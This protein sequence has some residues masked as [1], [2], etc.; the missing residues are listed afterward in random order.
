[1]GLTGS[2]FCFEVARWRGRGGERRESD[3]EGKTLTRTLTLTQTKTLTLREV[4]RGWERVRETERDSKILRV[5][6]GY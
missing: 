5:I 2:A 4:E 1:L 3:E 6:E